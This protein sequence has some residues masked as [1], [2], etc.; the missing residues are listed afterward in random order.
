M[1]LLLTTE[2]AAHELGVTPNTLSTW[3]N[4]GKGP[5]FVRFHGRTI[6]YRQA[7]LVAWVNKHGTLNYTAQQEPDPIEPIKRRRLKG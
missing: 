3:R 5:K 6:R 2:A 1:S 4:Q 7:D